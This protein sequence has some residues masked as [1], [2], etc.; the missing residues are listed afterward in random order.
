MKDYLNL[1]Y[2]QTQLISNKK[3]IVISLFLLI[4]NILCAQDNGKIDENNDIEIVNTLLNTEIKNTQKVYSRK[5]EFYLKGEP[6][7]KKLNPLN[8]VFGSLLFAYQSGLSIQFSADCL[9]EPSCSNFCKHCL[10][11]HG[12]FK[13]I[14]LTSDRLSRCNRIAQSDLHPIKFDEEK[15]RFI[16]TAEEYK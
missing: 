5:R 8:W 9:Y 16:D 12:L 10:R 4:S 1:T 3:T 7:K 2:P 15:R 6:L 13:G 14:L 11:E